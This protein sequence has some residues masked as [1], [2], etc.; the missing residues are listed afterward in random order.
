[1]ANTDYQLIGHGV[2]T[3][4]EAS[5]LTGV[6][7]RTVRR[8]L[9][10]YRFKAG[11]ESRSSPPVIT[12]EHAF[13]DGV[14]A[15]SFLDLQEVRF[16]DF[17]ARH[18]VGWKTLRDTHRETQKVL[19]D[20]HP[21]ATGRF[22]TDGRNLLL[23]MSRTRRDPGLLNIVAKQWEFRRIVAPFL[24]ELDYDKDRIVRWWPTAGRRWVV[25]DPGWSFGQPIVS[26]ESVPTAVLASAFAVDE[27]YDVVARWYEVSP[28]SV[29]DA[30][31]FER[32]LA[33]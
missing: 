11:D 27:S 20:R 12:P 4:A 28:R 16:V 32:Q 13:F 8:W 26:R 22:K 19:D 30:V 21:F 15:M 33:A 7:A 23:E 2:Y 10:G 14:P 1:M 29:R 5:R 3:L 25:V 18:G 6:G 24:R 17:F 31:E 9:M